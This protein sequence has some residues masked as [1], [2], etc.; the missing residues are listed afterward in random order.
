MNRL[1]E[2]LW[3][4]VCEEEMPELDGTCMTLQRQR[5]FTQLLLW[6]VCFHIDLT[7]M[8]AYD[9]EC[10]S[11]YSNGYDIGLQRAIDIMV[12]VYGVEL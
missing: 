12:E 10:N 4:K 3:T 6:D 2:E 9:S 8:C 7:K 11:E 5:L 1:I